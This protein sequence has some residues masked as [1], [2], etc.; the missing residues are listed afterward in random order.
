MRQAQCGDCAGPEQ[1]GQG[2]GAGWLD[3]DFHALP[4]EACGGDDFLFSDEQNAADTF[5]Q[6]GEGAR[7]E[8]GAEAIGDSVARFEG[9]QGAGLD[10][11]VGIVGAL[12]FAAEDGDARTKALNAEARA[13]EQAAAA[14]GGEDR[15]QVPYFF[16]ELLGGGGLAG[17]DAV[18]VVGMDERGAGFGLHAGGGFGAG[19]DFG[20]A[21]GDFAAVG[22]DGLALHAGRVFGHDDIGGDAA[23]GCG[24]G[25]GGTVVAAGEGDDAVGDL[26]VGHGEDGVAG[27]AD[28]EGASFLEIVTFEEEAGASDGVERTRGEYRGAMDVRGDA[29]VRGQDGG[30]VGRLI[31]GRVVRAGR[32]REVRG[33]WVEALSGQ[34]GLGGL[35]NGPLACKW[36]VFH[37]WALAGRCWR[38]RAHDQP[39]QSGLVDVLWKFLPSIKD[40]A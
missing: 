6:D 14:N 27:A 7:G 11:A 13:A 24:A 1:W 28:L 40:A 34:A 19:G 39:C 2:Y 18:V 15:V 22:F 21:E 33:H 32:R 4:D 8:R 16:E 29:G 25:Y 30:P 37:S 38:V 26:G 23:P 31:G 5:T 9:L 35:E 17:D 3:D 12:R 20:F 36:L 10:G